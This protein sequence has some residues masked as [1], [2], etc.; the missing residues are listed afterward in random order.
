MDN[1]AL[2]SSSLTRE[3][4]MFYEMKVTAEL[5]NEGL[6]DS[7]VIQKIIDNNLYQYP[8]EKSLKIRAQACVRRLRYIDEEMLMWINTKPIDVAKQVC[9]YTLMKDSRL[10]NDF[11]ITIIGEKYAVGDFYYKR[12]IIKEYFIQLQEQNK[13]VNLWSETTIKKLSSV[14]SSILKEVG[15]ID[16]FNSDHLNEIIIYYKLKEKIIL[17]NEEK[18]LLAFN[19]FGESNE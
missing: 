15:Y 6:T 5:L 8:T 10:V 1:K 9:L 17:N 12:S 14:I 3:P 19:A 16:N 7:Y 4:F 18:L 2:Y 13:K 11:F